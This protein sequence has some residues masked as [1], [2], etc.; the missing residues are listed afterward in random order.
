MSAKPAGSASSI[1]LPASV[2]RNQLEQARRELERNNATEAIAHVERALESARTPQILRA[3]IRLMHDAAD[4]RRAKELAVELTAIAPRVGPAEAKLIKRVNEH[5]EILSWVARSKAPR[6][7]SPVERRVLNI[8]AYSMPYYSNGYAVR[9]HGLAQG[10]RD[11]GW[12]ILPYT[13]LGFPVDQVPE[14][15]NGALPL[16]DRIDGIVYRRLLDATRY[17]TDEHTYLNSAIAVYRRVFSNERPAIVHGA[18]NRM[19]SLPALVAAK[20][21]GIPFVYEMRG[22]WEVTRASGDPA[23]EGTAAYRHIQTYETLLAKAADHVLTL[24][25]GMRQ[26]LIARGLPQALITVVP[27][28]VDVD[29][30]APRDRDFPLAARLGLA[31]DEPV[32]GYVGSFENYEGLDD[33]IAAAALLAQHGRRFR[34]LLIGDGPMLPTLRTQAERDGLGS[35]VIFAGRVPHSEVMRYY[36]LI[37]LCPF[38]RKPWKVCELVSPLKPLEAMAQGKTV[39]VSDT[40]ALTELVQDGRNGV[41]VRGADP[42][43]LARAIA[44]LLDDRGTREKLGSEARTWASAHRTWKAIGENC[45]EVYDL[46]LRG[47]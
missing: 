7:F 45:A 13:R 12:E 16:E 21:C 41:V 27:N 36:S 14:L 9:S 3:A 42:E 5:H 37:D 6:V 32:I 10:L 23:F 17:A 28:G 25:E 44:P 43:A 18:S 24:T 11:A 35:R 22:F 38:P 29:R 46:V 15:R 4:F 40:A 47:T 30:F 19:T 39:L 33:L 31:N 26:E 1:A 8:L 20:E 2:A 34:L